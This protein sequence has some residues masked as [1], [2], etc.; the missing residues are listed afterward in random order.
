[1][2]LFK[3]FCIIIFIISFTKTY[4]DLVGQKKIDSLILEL[5]KANGDS[6]RIKLLTA[7]STSHFRL[8]PKK[9]LK[10]GEDGLK[11]SKKINWEEGIRDNYNAIGMNYLYLSEYEKAIEHFTKAE[12]LANKIGEKSKVAEII[13]NIGKVNIR[14]SNYT[15]ALKLSLKALKINEE[16]NEKEQVANNLTQIGSINYH[17]SNF[18]KALEY[19]NQSLK[20]L[21]S[22]E[23]YNYGSKNLLNIGYI[24]L[25]K[26]DFKTALEY[27]KK[28]LKNSNEINENMG[29]SAALISI[30][31][32]Y[33]ET[34]DYSKALE[35][36]YKAQIAY[37]KI[38]NKRG[39]AMVYNNLG[40]LYH[41]ISKIPSN[42]LKNYNSKIISSN[43][44]DNLTKS[45]ENAHKS[46]DIFLNL[47]DVDA[48]SQVYNLLQMAYASKEEFQKAYI[49]TKKYE[50]YRDSVFNLKTK[51]TI[52]NLSSV[53]EKEVAEKE[54]EILKQ[55][56][57]INKFIIY[58]SSI[59]LIILLIFGVVIYR[60]RQKSELLLLNILP[61]KIANRLKRKEKPIADYFENVSIVFMDMAGFT[62]Y[63]KQVSA[64][65]LVEFLNSLFS[66]IDE[67]ALKYGLEKIKTIGDCY[68]AVAGVPEGRNDHTRSVLLFAL[69][70]NKIFR[71]YTQL[72]NEHV[73][74]RIGIESGSVIAGV[75]G[76]SKFTY[77]LWGES[78]NIASRMESSGVIGEIQVT[79]NFKT[80]YESKYGANDIKFEYRGEIE[81]KGTGLTKTWFVK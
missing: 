36:Y 64:T 58:I 11:I 66:D 8:N 59:G 27:F 80:T 54:S 15:E 55:K 31:N 34:K 48:I 42:K 71:K 46:L 53:R 35:Y 74:F 38:G 4:A 57:I 44:K 19:Y 13:S 76:K 51:K 12:I 68:M 14:K 25:E 28:S 18:D 67:I 41:K 16:I 75:I 22:I 61:T 17:L 77:D 49:Y 62:N 3:V 40:E 26:K 6:N 30:G 2:N 20:T 37:K 21:K 50:D 63:S 78:V 47:N 79:D 5:P 29:T 9:G 45:I 60:Q 72:N 24:Y 73:E 81:I 65:E 69:E 7:L 32:I 43:S 70:A 52:A 10:Y 33:N 56:N 1:M 39:V 23:G